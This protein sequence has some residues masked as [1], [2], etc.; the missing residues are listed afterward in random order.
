M[1]PANGRIALYL[2]LVFGGGVAVGSFGHHLLT[3][4][5]V[6]ATTLSK[7]KT[8]EDYRKEYVAEMRQRLHLSDDQL[9]AIEKILDR[10]KERYREFRERTRPEMDRIQMEQTSDI[11]ALLQADQ[12]VEYEKMRAER[13]QRKRKPSGGM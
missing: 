4:K 13:D 2:L 10:T 9:T 1:K 8:P 12:V 6:I 7:R 5:S 3:V 11:R